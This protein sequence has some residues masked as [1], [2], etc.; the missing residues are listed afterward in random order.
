[1]R[2]N[3]R[4]GCRIMDRL[5]NERRYFRNLARRLERRTRA[6]GYGGIDEAYF[7]SVVEGN[8]ATTASLMTTDVPALNDG[9]MYAAT[10]LMPGSPIMGTDSGI[11]PLEWG[12]YITGVTR[13]VVAIDSEADSARDVKVQ[14]VLTGE[15]VVKGTLADTA[16]TV[17]CEKTLHGNA[18]PFVAIHPD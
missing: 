13:S 1:M 3:V 15:F 12:R 18:H 8:D 17:T 14:I 16:E 10:G 11:T 7:A 9:A 5:F 6:S 2:G 4:D